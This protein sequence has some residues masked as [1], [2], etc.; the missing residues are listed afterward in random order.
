MFPPC[1]WINYGKGNGGNGDLLQ[2]DLC[3]HAAAPRT[4][5][6]SAPDPVAR[7]Y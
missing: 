6:V 4:V 1:S 7:H 5:L 3:P 2:K